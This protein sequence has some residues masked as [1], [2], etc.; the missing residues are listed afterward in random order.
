[1]ACSGTALLYFLRYI[2]E[3]VL[4]RKM[5]NSQEIMMKMDIIIPIHYYT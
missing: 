4:S 2:M 1:M 5:Y 3:S